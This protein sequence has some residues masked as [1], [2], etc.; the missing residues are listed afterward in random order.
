M[1]LNEHVWIAVDDIDEQYVYFYECPVHFY[2]RVLVTLVR[3]L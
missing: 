1:V 3:Q 2:T